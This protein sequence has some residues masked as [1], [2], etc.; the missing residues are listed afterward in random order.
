MSLTTLYFWERSN[1]TVGPDHL[2]H[3]I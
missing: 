2:K 1:G 3:Y